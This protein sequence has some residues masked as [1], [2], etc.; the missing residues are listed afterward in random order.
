VTG[1]VAQ[2]K[3]RDVFDAG[4]DR[5]L[6]V[7]TDRISAFDV[8]L[9]DPI[10]DKGRILTGLSLFWF[11]R[12]RELVPNHVITVE[13]RGFPE[14]F[15]EDPDLAGRAILVRRAEPIPMECVARGYLAGSGW[16][17]YQASGHV[18]GVELPSG[19]P[20]RA[21]DTTCRLHRRRLAITLA[22]DSTNG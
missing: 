15:A 14:P 18:C 11:G 20:R 17:Q 3:V 19:P 2:G 13:R 10:P 7:A 16:T 21:R 4:D 8:V 12:S 6:L 1:L 22:W 5:L 9:P